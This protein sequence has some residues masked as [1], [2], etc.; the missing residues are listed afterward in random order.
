MAAVRVMRA[1]EAAKD[2]ARA[3]VSE[4]A[5]AMLA[6]DAEIDFEALFGPDEA[7]V[8]PE[9]VVAEVEKPAVPVA[10]VSEQLRPQ[11][12]IRAVV[13]PEDFDV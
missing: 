6:P 1:R 11:R 12:S 13:D 3:G 2:R 5:P 10:P 8:S 4:P 7:V 9:P